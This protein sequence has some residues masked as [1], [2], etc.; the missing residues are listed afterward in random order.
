MSKLAVVALG[1]NALLRGNQRGT[2]EEQ[3]RNTEATLENLVPL[4]REE[5]NLVIGHGNGPQVGNILLQKAAGEEMFDVPSMPLYV[6][7][8]ESQGSIGYMIE[9][10]LRNVLTRHGIKRNVCCLVS[11]VVVDAE[12]SA[13]GNPTKRVGR[14][15][16]HDQ[17]A[18]LATE[19]GWV[20]KEEKR[21]TGTG[22]RRVVPSPTPLEV[23]NAELIGN[24]A[25]Q[26]VIVIATGGGGV[27]VSRSAHGTLTPQEAVID[28][29]SV[30]SVL[31]SSIGA[32]QFYILT[33]VPY[34]YEHFNQPAQRPLPRLTTQEA[35]TYLTRGEFGEG[36]MAPKVRA[37]IDFIK[38][39]GKE[40]I[41]TESTQL[42]KE[43]VG[44]R[45]VVA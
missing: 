43:G 8:A 30:C 16:T 33:D 1:G 34:A 18:A 21:T 19:R 36:N 7:V 17:A 45:I 3:L 25:K 12:D 11:Y 42:G 23:L 28:K 4:I 35:T 14:L 44:T 40:S 27:A 13:F 22:M 15:Y 38:R 24:L 39:G 32:E 10:S 41:I 9:H 5:Q 6:C 37:C 2:L 26:G 29:D 20:F 31:A